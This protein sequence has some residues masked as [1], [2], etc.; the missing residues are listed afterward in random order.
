MAEFKG[1]RATESGVS[2]ASACLPGLGID[3]EHRRSADG[4][5]EQISIRLQAL[6]SFQAVGRWLEST[7]PLALWMAA[8]RLAWLPWLAVARGGMLARELPAPEPRAARGTGE[9]PL[10]G[11]DENR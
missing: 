1:A 9:A 8:T 5:A 4:N 10:A 7:N 6:P 2:K 3:I 11:Q